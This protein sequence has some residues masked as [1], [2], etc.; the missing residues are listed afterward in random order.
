MIDFNKYD[1]ENPHI[2]EMFKKYAFEAKDKGFSKYS[3]K[4]IFEIIRWQT[5]IKGNDGFKANNT[6]TPDYSRKMIKE[7]PEFLGFFNLKTLKQKRK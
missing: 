5:S 2:W 1:R 3:S 6:Y 4:G 7:F